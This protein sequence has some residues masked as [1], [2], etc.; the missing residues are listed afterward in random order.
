MEANRVRWLG[1]GEHVDIR[2]LSPLLK[3]ALIFAV[4]LGLSLLGILLRSPGPLSS[5]WL[6]NAV[7]LGLLISTQSPATLR[8]VLAAAAGFVLADLLTGSSLFKTSILTAGNLVGV[9]TAYAAFRMFRFDDLRMSRPESLGIIVLAS[10][11]GALA[12]GVTGLIANPILFNEPA[13]EGYAYWT[14][15][16][17]TNFVAILPLFLVAPSLLDPTKR[18]NAEG[19]L[20]SKPESFLPLAACIAGMIVAPALPGPL[21]IALPIPGLIWCALT[22]SVSLTALLSF[23]CAMWMLITMTLGILPWTFH[24][25]SQSDLVGLR[26]GVTLV[27]LPPVLIAS[28]MRARSEALIEAA[29]ARDASEQAMSARALLLATMAHELRTPLN[30][31]VG[32]ASVIETSHKKGSPTQK[33]EQYATYIR[34]SGM[35]LAQLVTDLLDTAKIEAGKLA[36]ELKETPSRPVV[37]QSLHLVGGLAMQSGV[38]ILIASEVWPDV[39]VDS[40]AIKQVLINLLSNA[41]KYSPRGSTIDITTEIV[42]GPDKKDRLV[43]R[44]KDAGQGISAEDLARIGKAYQQAAAADANKPQGT[45]LGLSLS[46]RLIEQHGGELRLESALGRGTT[47]LFDLTLADAD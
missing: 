36:L 14:A 31:I 35:H 29:K 3:S 25:V 18:T 45:G 44:I 17:F 47:A 5:F 1:R 7:L 28:V 8:D 42:R 13:L 30:S 37:E 46:K 9:L 20:F 23:I 19:T 10:L 26:I 43:V 6:A 40:R 21:T 39:I 34:E 24:F 12:S 38:T 16:E 32:F 33:T 15:T 22:Y 27:C 41:V 2:Q 11:G 4:V